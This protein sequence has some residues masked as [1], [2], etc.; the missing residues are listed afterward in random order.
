VGKALITGSIIIGVCLVVA[1]FIV[2][3]Y[4]L[5]QGPSVRRA[6]VRQYRRGFELADTIIG[7]ISSET[8]EWKEIDSVLAS[9]VQE[10]L[11]EYYRK[12]KEMQREW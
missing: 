3:V 2:V 12:I 9:Q 1:L 10:H 6:K 5:I 11:K 4:R 7:K 8:V